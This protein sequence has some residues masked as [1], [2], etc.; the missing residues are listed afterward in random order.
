MRCQIIA[1]C[2]GA[3]AAAAPAEAARELAFP[4][5]VGFGAQ[6]R[7]GRGGDVYHVT[8]LTDA[9]A[10]SLR[11]AVE[12]AT[13][14]RTIVFEVAGT[15][16]LGA[17]LR[18][19]EKANLT[20]AGQTSPGGITTRGY[21]VE[22]LR[23]Q[24]VVV[25]H[26][27]F[28]TGDIHA[29]GVPGKPGRG[30]ADLNG[31]AADALS[32]LESQHV[33]IDH[34]S[35]SWSMDET[36]SVTKSKYVTVQHSLISESLNDS[37]HPEGEHGYGSLVRGTG[38]EG[39]SFYRNLWA[40]HLRRSP[41]L[42]GQQDPP[43]PGVPALGLDVD[44]VGNVMY[45]WGFLPT[46]TV[47]DPYRLRINLIGNTWIARSTDFCGCVFFQI[48]GTADDVNVFPRANRFDEDFDARLSPKPLG[49]SDLLG[50]FTF[51]P[52]PFKFDRP[53]PAARSTKPSVRRLL[54]Q[55]G[56]SLWRD[57]VDERV[58]AQVEDQTGGLIDSQDD[59]GGWPAIATIGAV[60]EDLDRDGMA[61]DWERRR[62]L[63]PTSADDRNGYDL[64]RAYT[65][66]EV[67]LHALTR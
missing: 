13:G 3:L 48:E 52:K 28:R 31:S 43:P 9:G 38:E 40:H 25:R 59:V 44:L 36:L 55:V 23:S 19:R 53:M 11:D 18:I 1:L 61:D 33:M 16:D 37:F 7:G 20:I 47:S 64:R 65:N 49:P 54:R 58:V 4:G 2:V 63:D 32:I 51:V 60:A 24:H 14:P 66:L 39:Y 42:G 8:T 35:A 30:N 34:V 5:A 56:A 15:I 45:D 57:A 17:P 10:G 27:R 67:Y 41:S 22:M 12:S 62:G 21:P 50:F 26:I 6:S 29:A 46:H